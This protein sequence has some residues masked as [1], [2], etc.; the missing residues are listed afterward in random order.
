MKTRSTPWWEVGLLVAVWLAIAAAA[1]GQTIEGPDE[2]EA[3]V[4]AWFW[5]DAAES[6]FPLLWWSDELSVDKQH[7][8]QG[9][10]LFFAK[11]PGEYWVRGLVI[12]WETHSVIQLQKRVVVSGVGPGP[13]PPPPPGAKQVCFFRESG[14]ITSLP[15]PQRILLSGLVIRDELKAAGHTFV[16]SFDPD[17]TGP[18]GNVPEPLAPWF[19]AVRDA[20]LPAMLVAPKNG[21]TIEVHPC[22][23]DAAGLWK[24]L[25]GGDP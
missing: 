4:P 22:P 11:T 10:G 16:G 14:T 24:L 9:H 7:I 12:A 23:A 19:R 15:F 6:G 2:V 1:S 3:G 18:D 13:P 8:L 5:I 17:E 20:K 21:G 25:G